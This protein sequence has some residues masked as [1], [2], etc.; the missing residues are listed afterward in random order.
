VLGEARGVLLWGAGE[1]VHGARCYTRIIL[2]N[3][4]RPPVAGAARRAPG[5]AS[6]ARRRLGGRPARGPRHR[7][8]AAQ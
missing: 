7:Q 4:A 3:S 6:S 1:G 5:S 2:W 8:Q